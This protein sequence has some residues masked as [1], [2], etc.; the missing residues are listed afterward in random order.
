[1]SEENITQEEINVGNATITQFLE[2]GYWECWTKGFYKRYWVD[3]FETKEDCELAIKKH[4]E[5]YKDKLNQEWANDFIK[6]QEAKFISKNCIEDWNCLM[7]AWS[8]FKI[9][10]EKGFANTQNT[11]KA[12]FYEKTISNAVSSNDIKKTWQT[13]VNAINFYNNV[14]N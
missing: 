6:N 2:E 9:I 3:R 14:N 4:T 10:T 11:T 5:D 13:I 12:N 8:K 1:M 7:K